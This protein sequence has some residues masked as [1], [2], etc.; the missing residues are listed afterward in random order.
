MKNAFSY[1]WLDMKVVVRRVGQDRFQLFCNSLP[2]NIDDF[3]DKADTLK[4]Y[5]PKKMFR[6]FVPSSDWE[7]LQ[8]Q[9]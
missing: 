3:P 4:C 8:Y 9:T 2:E 1:D 7:S 6:S 5:F